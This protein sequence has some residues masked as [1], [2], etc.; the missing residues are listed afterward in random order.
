MLLYIALNLINN[1]IV[2]YK[3]S[4][5]AI[6]SINNIIYTLLFLLFIYFNKDIA[7]IIILL[8]YKVI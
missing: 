2:F 3:V 6:I 1:N 7:I 4:L 5:K 8:Y